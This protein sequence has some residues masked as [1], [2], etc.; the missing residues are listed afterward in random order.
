MFLNNSVFFVATAVLQ[1]DSSLNY[2]EKMSIV[3][4]MKEKNFLT[5][6]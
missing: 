2:R 5:F 1:S 3:I 6:F 4:V